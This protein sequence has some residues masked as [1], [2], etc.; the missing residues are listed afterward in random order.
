M[1]IAEEELLDKDFDWWTDGLIKYYRK[2]GWGA[3]PGGSLN[4]AVRTELLNVG[5][6]PPPAFES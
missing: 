5:Q 2:D 1:T 6:F 4:P 3:G